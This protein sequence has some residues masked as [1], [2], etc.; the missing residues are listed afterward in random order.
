[1][2]ERPDGTL[3]PKMEQLLRTRYN[4]LDV[5][6]SK[7]F[8]QRPESLVPRLKLTAKPSFMPNDRYVI[9]LFDTVYFWHGHG[10][11]L[12][13]I[14]AIWQHLDLPF[15]TL[16]LYTNH[17]G[18]EKEVDALCRDLCQFDRPTV[19]E[20]LI[21]PRNYNHDQYHWQDTA[22]E[23]IEHHVLCLMAGND[24]SH[25]Y[26]TYAGLRDIDQERLVMTIRAP[27]C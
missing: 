5:I 24:R 4:L 11:C 10:I 14:F 6:E 13:N 23:H 12:N 15:Y 26:A 27:T 20:T 21:N 25:R 7:E 18:I 19:I 3:D 1:M 22:L 17:I 16:L 9:V 8:D 2:I